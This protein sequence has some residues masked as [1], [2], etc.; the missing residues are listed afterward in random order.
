MRKWR[1]ATA[2]CGDE[3][4]VSHQIVVPTCYRNDVLHLAHDSPLAGHLGV[5]KTYQRVLTFLLAW[6]T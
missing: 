6:V 4:Q 5:N 1:P 3:W 2:P